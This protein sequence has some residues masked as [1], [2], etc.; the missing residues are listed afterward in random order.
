MTVA[1]LIKKLQELDQTAPILISNQI[2][3]VE[4]DTVMETENMFQAFKGSRTWMDGEI[5]D[6]GRTCFVL[7]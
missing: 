1:D 7:R 2:D 5:G 3:F 4:I 6:G